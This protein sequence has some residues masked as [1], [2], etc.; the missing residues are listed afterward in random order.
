MLGCAL[1]PVAE[2]DVF[3]F[4]IKGDFDAYAPRQPSQGR[5]GRH[6]PPRGQDGSSRS[7]LPARA[8]ATQ[9]LPGRLLGA[10][11]RNS[12]EVSNSPRQSQR[13]LSTTGNGIRSETAGNWIPKWLPYGV[14]AGS[15]V[16]PGPGDVAVSIYPD[17]QGS[18]TEVDQEHVFGSGSL[19]RGSRPGR[20]RANQGQQARRYR[21]DAAG[22]L[23]Y[24]AQVR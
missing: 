19:H 7:I 4:A 20:A 18:V 9:K 14:L 13:G 10:T 22:Q 8:A 15:G 6:H 12:R 1:D 17:Q 21:P 23:R 11:M 5:R 16:L 3:V 2:L 24:V